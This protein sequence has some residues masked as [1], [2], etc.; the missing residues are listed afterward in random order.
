[1]VARMAKG[2]CY[3]ELAQ[4]SNLDFEM[5]IESGFGLRPIK[6]RLA[7]IDIEKCFV[8]YFKGTLKRFDLSLDISI[9]TP[10]QKRVW[11]LIKEIPF[12]QVR[13]YKWVAEQMSIPKA[14]RAVGNANGKNPIPIIIPCH[15]I[16]QANGNLGGYSAGIEIK[17]KLL[18]HE[19]ISI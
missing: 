12:G 11:M 2:I 1:M 14:G 13:S 3:V 17:K 7:I 8:K 6:D 5:Y 10:F 19:G 9:D 18:L 15:R 4:E 16:I